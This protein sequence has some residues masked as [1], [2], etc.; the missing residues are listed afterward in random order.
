MVLLLS[1]WLGLAAFALPQKG[2]K[3]EASVS[4]AP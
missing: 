4:P 3:A 2:L 1:V